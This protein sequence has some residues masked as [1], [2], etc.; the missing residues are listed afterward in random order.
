MKLLIFFFNRAS[1]E[2]YEAE[3]KR[4][5]GLSS[6]AVN[7]YLNILENEGFLE[8]RKSGKMSFYMLRRENSV[9]RHLKTAYTLSLPFISEIER[10]GKSAGMKVFLYG[11]AARGE[12]DEE[13]DIDLLVIGEAGFDKFQ[14]KI[15]LLKSETGRE[16]RS[17]FFRRSEWLKMSQKDPAFYERVEKDKIELV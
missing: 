13:S 1:S 15:S 9:V 10:I 12:D 17:S 3:V 4:G 6:G 5:T 2:F 11:S 16:I 8:K 7:R 14:K